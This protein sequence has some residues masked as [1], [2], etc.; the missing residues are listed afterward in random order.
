[1]NLYWINVYRGQPS[2]TS[3]VVFTMNPSRYGRLALKTISLSNPSSVPV[4]VTLTVTGT[5]GTFTRV[6]DVRAR[7]KVMVGEH[8]VL[9]ENGDTVSLQ[10]VPGGLAWVDVEGGYMK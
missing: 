10:A 1:M 9:S 7:G 5:G 3:T 4:Q 8:T 6:F 2:A